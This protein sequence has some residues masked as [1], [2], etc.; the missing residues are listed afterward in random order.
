MKRK[1]IKFCSMFIPNS[2]ERKSFREKMQIKYCPEDTTYEKNHR[3]YNMGEFSYLGMNTY[4]KNVKDTKIGKYCS[5]SHEVMIGLSQHPTDCLTTHGFICHEKCPAINNILTVP[6]E[7][8][9]SF[10]GLKPITIGNDVW[11]GF[12][13]IIMDGVNIADGAI[14]AAGAVVT[15]DVPPYAIVGGVPAKVIKY[16]FDTETIN[17]LLELR[18]WDFPP[19]FVEKLPFRDV[20]ECIRICEENRA[21]RGSKKVSGGGVNN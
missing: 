10:D 21:V 12:R 3:R 2:A 4:I 15:H 16:R 8:V 1:L 9:V 5:I 14:V 6:K 7:N 20:N 18:W 13:A 19:E 11:I 17:K